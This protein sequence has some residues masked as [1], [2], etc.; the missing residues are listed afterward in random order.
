MCRWASQDVSR[1]DARVRGDASC[2]GTYRAAEGDC[3]GGDAELEA[4]G[5]WYL[6]IAQ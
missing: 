1:D 5:R 6:R 2:R 3:I 4:W